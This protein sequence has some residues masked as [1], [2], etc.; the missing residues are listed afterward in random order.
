MANVMFTA[1]LEEGN[2][3]A[4]FG[5]AK[6]LRSRGHTVVYAGV[7]DAEGFV[8]AEGF[9]FIPL[10]LTSYPG[11]SKYSSGSFMP[12]D[13]SRGALCKLLVDQGGELDAL[14][15][16]FS[17]DLIVVQPYL[18]LES[19]ILH[20][21]FGTKIVHFRS[22]YVVDSR[23]NVITSYCKEILDGV[24]HSDKLIAFL[25]DRGYPA[26]DI[27]GIAHA[28]SEFPEFVLLPEGYEPD[29]SKTPNTYYIGASIDRSRHQPSFDLSAVEQNQRL[30]FCTLGSQSH[31]YS[32]KSE[33]FF[34]S[35]LEAVAPLHDVFLVMAV[36][37]AINVEAFH[38]PR[39]A[40]LINW[41]PQLKMLEKAQAM[42]M[43]GGMGTTRECILT[44]VPMLAHPMM[45]DQF[46]SADAICRHGIGA[47]T[48]T[49]CNS[50]DDLRDQIIYVLD[51][52]EI[53][54]SLTNIKVRFQ[55]A[56]QAQLGVNAVES[57]VS[58]SQ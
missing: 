42:I 20:L 26:G 4:T 19:L 30:V 10:L 45:R 38:S 43:H 32:P 47:R 58:T 35:V 44:E 12:T 27:V 40:M 18:A 14:I 7:S 23:V 6:Q 39:N 11:G 2:I 53:R 51:S 56:D 22:A 34:Q 25:E 33:L 5:L 3:F 17:P 8:R 37:K 36:G 16:A 28:I 31:R 41:A 24:Q 52:P 15:G 13:E 46:A 1:D 21:R 48:N 57:I 49:E 55:M 29:A 50:V 9:T 54:T